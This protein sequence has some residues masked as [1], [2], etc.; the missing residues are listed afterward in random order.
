MPNES[1]VT[2][3]ARSFLSIVLLILNQMPPALGVRVDSDTF[4]SSFSFDNGNG[5]RQRVGPWTSGPGWRAVDASSTPPASVD[6]RSQQ[7]FIDRQLAR[8]TK[9]FNFY[10]GHI[11]HA[12]CKRSVPALVADDPNIGEEE[13]DKA[14]GESYLDDHWSLH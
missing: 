3:M 5:G 10:A 9:H 11:P 14:A 2:F 12:V 6:L 1:L 13:I 7:E 8:W 4:L